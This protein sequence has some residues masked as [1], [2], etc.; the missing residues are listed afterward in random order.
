MCLSM[1]LDIVIWNTDSCWWLSSVDWLYHSRLFLLVNNKPLCFFGTE[2][3]G[4]LGIFLF[5]VNTVTSLYWNRSSCTEMQNMCRLLPNLPLSFGYSPFYWFTLLWC[6]LPH[7][8]LTSGS[9]CFESDVMRK[10]RDVIL[11]PYC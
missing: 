2:Y 8:P 5:H 4:C 10:N 3:Y 6:V 7:L 9:F 1:K 11:M